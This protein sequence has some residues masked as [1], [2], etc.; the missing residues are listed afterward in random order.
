MNS[1]SAEA[2]KTGELLTAAKK[3]IASYDENNPA[4]TADVHRDDCPCFRCAVDNFR[5]ALAK[6]AP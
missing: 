6:A 4:R 2:G 1:P 5:A 3:L